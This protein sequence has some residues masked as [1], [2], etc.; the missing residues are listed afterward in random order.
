MVT[1]TLNSKTENQ[2]VINWGTSG[3]VSDVWCSTD[4]GG[5]WFLVG[6]NAGRSSSYEISGLDA[7]TVYLIKT[8]VKIAATQEIIQSDALSVETFNWPYAIN[9]PRFT[10]GEKLTLSFYN[11]LS[12]NITVDLIGNDLSLIS[13]DTTRST[14][15]SGYNS[16]EVIN[17]LYDS[18]PTSK[19][20]GYRVE[21]RYGGRSAI[22]PG[23]GY[24][25][26]ENVCA[27]QIG[28]CQYSDTNNETVSITSYDKLIIRNKS[29]VKFNASGIAGERGSNIVSCNVT[30]NSQTY[31]MT[32]NGA[33]AEVSGV[34]IDS[35]FDIPAVFTVTDSRG[36]TTRKSLTVSMLDWETPT[37]LIS[38]KRKNN[39]YS[40]CDIKVNAAYSDL[41][42]SNSVT[43]KARSKKATD[44]AY[45]AYVDLADGV[46]SVLNL[47][48]N[49]EWLT[50]VKVE[51]IFSQNIYTIKTSRGMPL[52]FL[53]NI[54]N[55][56]GVNCFPKENSSLEVN[57]INVIP[58][59]ATMALLGDIQN[60]SANV[61]T[62][63][64]FDSSTIAGSN[65]SSYGGGVQIR[66][67]ITKVLIS[68]SVFFDRL[69]ASGRRI[70]RIVKNSYS[71]ANTLAWSWG[72][73]SQSVP[74]GVHIT[75]T[76]AQVN[77]GDVIYMFYYTPSANDTIIGTAEG[78][79]TSLTVQ[80]IF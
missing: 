44:A 36:L 73:F 29:V 23:G 7:G 63:I 22:K 32:L 46:S 25:V 38:L 64:P 67:R 62:I 34:V 57:G 19:S 47:D 27:P 74:G 37:G 72:E 28:V 78:C 53:D 56:V 59:A 14:Y 50:E 75:P 9:A 42:G 5:T 17:K 52:I 35:A 43:I 15:L 54:K 68:G 10:I 69:G 4:N 12:R 48:N 8:K 77:T 39:F 11:P 76:V 33:N 31:P 2:I 16:T 70:I 61:Y 13:R 58:S 6:N 60:L 51:D 24:S 30:V 65:L 1:Q 49:Y 45:G 3:A 80:T 18:I 40:E 41:R 26:N 71:A 79:L 20:G 55:S 21:V 66:G